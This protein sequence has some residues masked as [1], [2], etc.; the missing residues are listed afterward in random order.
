MLRLC[1]AK[2]LH[3]LLE[4]TPTFVKEPLSGFVK[5]FDNG[6]VYHGTSPPVLP[7]SSFGVRIA[8]QKRF[9]SSVARIRRRITSP[10]AM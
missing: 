8:G 1:G 6:I 2:P 3:E 9:S 5:L 4:V 7:I 10:F